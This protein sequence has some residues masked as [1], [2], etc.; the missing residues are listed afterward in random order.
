M[1]RPTT[2][3]ERQKKILALVNKQGTLESAALASQLRVSQATVQSDLKALARQNCLR[4]VQGGAVRLEVEHDQSPAFCNSTVTYSHAP[5]LLF[6]AD[7]S[8]RQACCPHCGL[9]SLITPHTEV[10]TVQV[11]DVLSGIAVAAPTATYV[12]E[13]DLHV[14]CTP[15]VL[16][17]AN[18][19]D[20]ERFR[21]G[22]GGQVVTLEEALDLLSR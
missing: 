9:M 18:R 22:F 20:A 21:V 15:T 4:L 10:A 12:F 3:R 7:G 6:M 17:F 13:P 1:P 14:C 2:V 8:L 19:H 16:A 11:T 5:V